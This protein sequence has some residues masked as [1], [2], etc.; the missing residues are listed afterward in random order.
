LYEVRFASGHTEEF[1]KPSSGLP[2]SL[3]RNDV[4]SKLNAGIERQPFHEKFFSQLEERRTNVLKLLQIRGTIG[5]NLKSWERIF[6]SVLPQQSDDV[7]FKKDKDY[8]NGLNSL[9]SKYLAEVQVN[10]FVL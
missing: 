9:F 4:I 7:K 8:E 5:D 6:S 1:V 2:V 3:N 10:F